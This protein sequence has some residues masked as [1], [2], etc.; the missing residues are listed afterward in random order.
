MVFARL[1]LEKVGRTQ[2]FGIVIR[3]H[4]CVTLL[5]I[6]G[7]KILKADTAHAR[8]TVPGGSECL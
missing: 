3:L 2:I 5:F 7:W 6:A 1:F 8:E 4:S